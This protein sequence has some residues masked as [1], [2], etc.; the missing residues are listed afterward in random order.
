VITLTEF[1]AKQP[2][3]SEQFVRAASIEEA[4]SMGTRAKFP[5]PELYLYCESDTCNGDR[6]FTSDDPAFYVRRNEPHL[7]YLTYSCKNCGKSIKIYALALTGVDNQ[8][9]S[10]LKIGEVPPFGTPTP[11]RLLRILENE[12]DYFLRGRRSENQG[13][14]I[15]AFA[16]YRRVI[17][18]QKARIFDE[19]V[20]V[21]KMTK[22]PPALVS[23]IEKAKTETQFS[24]AVESLKGAIP[25]S[26]LIEG[27][28]PLTLLHRALSEGLHAR[29]DEECLDLASN[30][31]IVLSS[32]ADKLG[33]ILKEQSE[34]KSA[35]KKL[36]RPGPEDN[37]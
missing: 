35:I 21:A 14:G 6:F 15:G 3:G 28:N 1:L 20:K 11:P 27:H 30:I 17:E 10:A 33:E 9:L 22:A 34:L 23:A 4:T 31:R 24:K 26:L 37:T 36:I 12:K 32:F 2:P 29:T 8:T 19:V 5:P 25:D 18:N 7:I 13:L 16:Y